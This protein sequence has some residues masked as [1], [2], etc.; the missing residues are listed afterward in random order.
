MQLFT[1]I[2]IPMMCIISYKDL[3][4]Y[5]YLIIFSYDNLLQ[6]TVV[7]DTLQLYSVICYVGWVCLDAYLYSNLSG[8]LLI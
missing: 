7:H 6:M 3:H 2:I 1:G 5:D 8:Y 4:G